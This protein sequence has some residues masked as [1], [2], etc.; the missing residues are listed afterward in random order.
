MTV[1]DFRRE[2]IFADRMKRNFELKKTLLGFKCIYLY[3]IARRMGIRL[4]FRLI[5]MTYEALR[6][7]RRGQ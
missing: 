1:F 4:P 5:S 7:I 6:Q 2:K 3:A